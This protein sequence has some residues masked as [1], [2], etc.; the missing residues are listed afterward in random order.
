MKIIRPV[1]LLDAMLDSSN[2]SE[3]SP[4][5]NEWSNVTAYSIGDEV[6]VTYTGAGASVAT[7]LVYT[8]NFAHTGKDPTL[9]ANR[10]TGNGWD[11][12]DATNRWRAFNNVLQ[13]G[14][15]NADTIEYEITPGEGVNAAALFG[16]DAQTV[17]IQLTDPVDG[18]VYDED[19]S[20]ISPSGITDWWLYYT[21]EIVREER[22]FV[23]D[24][25][26]YPDATLD[27]IVD[28]TGGTAEVGEI[29]FGKSFVIGDSQNGA[30][31][32]IIDYSIKNTDD[33]G[34]TTIAQGAYADIADVNVII[35]TSRFN[36]IH[37]TLKAYRSQPLVWVP[38]DDYEQTIVYG[39]YRNFRNAI[40][41]PVVSTTL[42]QLEGLT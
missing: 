37:K 14:A 23:D 2:V 26:H 35:Q 15:T 9:A 33:D 39:Y 7:H 25:P 27:I 11:I 16:V 18:L 1:A 31:F 40:T 19:Y 32:G 29:V 30:N 17:T 42:L 6:T 21:E 8:C 10:G 41:G 38:A 12:T 22:L 20:M 13:L 28:D 24:L 5:A 36:E 4:A 34:N 3:T